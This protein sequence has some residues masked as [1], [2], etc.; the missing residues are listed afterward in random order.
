[1]KKLIIFIGTIL[2]LASC[3][4]EIDLDLN[5]SN[6]KYVI[7]AELPQNEVATV[8]LIKTVNF[9]ESNNFPTV[10]GAIVTLSDDKGNTEQLKETANGI[11]KSEKTKG[12]V[13]TAYTLTVKSDGNTFTAKSVM[14]KQVK[15]NGLRYE[16]SSFAPPG[17]TVKGRQ[18]VFPVYL[19]PQ[20]LG[21]N[22]R[23]KQSKN[24]VLD[25]NILVTNDN[26]G[27]GKPNQKPL[28]SVGFDIFKGDK[29]TVEMQSIDAAV[30]NYLYTL[31]SISGNGPG[32]GTA[33]S[34]PI[35]NFSG[36]ALGYFSAYSKD[37]FTVEI[38]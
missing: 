10:N 33:P 28:F 16:K 29:V 3:E 20:E 38:K 1:M 37:I 30:Y 22:Y 11:Y 4:K 12:S 19:D 27:N 6:T 36:G 23:F 15:L 31:S 9:T 34:N 32:G 26:L 8:I 24:G 18:I 35:S 5:K 7:E 13:G 14:P 17:D 21:N 25:K 2:S